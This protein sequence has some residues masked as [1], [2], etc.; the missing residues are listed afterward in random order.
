MPNHSQSGPTDRPNYLALAA[1]ARNMVSQL[2]VSR[3]DVHLEVGL[4]ASRTILCMGTV[5]SAQPRNTQL[6]P[7]PGPPLRLYGLDMH[8]NKLIPP[9]ALQL[10]IDLVPASEIHPQ[11]S[12]LQPVHGTVPVAR[13]GDEEAYLL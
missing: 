11:Q 3:H 7:L 5:V 8:V 9:D 2:W 1:Q 4:T 13:L 12:S 10:V 6:E